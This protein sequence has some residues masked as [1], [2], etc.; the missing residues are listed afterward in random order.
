M[1]RIRFGFRDFAGLRRALFADAPNEAAAVLLA[2]NAKE[3]DATQLL[4]REMHPVPTE[5]CISRGP[6]EIVVSP[7]F[8]APLIKRARLEK[9]SLLLTH[10]HP[11][12]ET[13]QFSPQDDAGEKVLLPTL[14]QRAPDGT[15]GALL[16]S[17]RD[18]AARVYRS[19]GEELR[20]ERVS[21][22]DVDGV[23][24]HFARGTALENP[25][26]E[27]HDRTIRAIGPVGQG[28]L[29]RLHV[30]IVG[31]GGIGSMVAEQLAHLG[32]QQFTLLDPDHVE[33]S[34]L[35]RLV[36]ARASDVGRPKVD[37][38]RDLISSIQPAAAVSAHVG[39][40]LDAADAR[41]LVNVDV[42][43]CCT[44]SH[45]SR[46]ILNQLAYQYVVP[47]VDMG[48][49]IDP[50]EGATN[51]VGRV[52]WLAP[53]AAC[54]VCQRLLDSEEVRRDL[55]SPEE[56]ARDPY[57]SGVR[58]LQ[59]AVVSINGIVA[60]LGVTMLLSTVA[61]LPLSARHQLYVGPRGVV[62]TIQASPNPAC[63]VCSGGGA[64]QR[65][66]QWTMPWRPG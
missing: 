21:E 60:S 42:V 34:N 18:F 66:D 46:A 62:R 53:G 35:G 7:I 14:F 26:V 5:A 9:W 30:G 1:N 23:Q 48:V 49:R 13:A 63:V 41:R 56:R 58:V 12:A 24:F 20:F 28:L 32:V 61:G 57:V 45:G 64:L 8:L 36:G 4:V 38:A 51:V 6:R 10:S 52:Q 54:L 59:P 17:Q 3:S 2:A 33:R 25:V 22:V 47:T 16:L 37:V 55:L 27:E 39:S 11:F 19:T 15:H 40:V 44:D 50:G 31:V 43:A 29:R 65:G